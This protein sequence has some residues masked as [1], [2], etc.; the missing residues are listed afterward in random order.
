MLALFLSLFISYSDVQTV[1]NS[2]TLKV[3]KLG[4]RANFIHFHI[5]K[6]NNISLQGGS[7]LHV[8]LPCSQLVVEYQVD[9]LATWSFKHF[10]LS[11]P[12]LSVTWISKVNYSPLR[13]GQI[14]WWPKESYIVKQRHYF[15]NKGPSSQSYGFSSG[16]VWMWDLDCEETWVLKNWC[17]ELWCWRRLLRVPWTAGRSNQSVLK[18]ISPGCSLEA[19]MLK[20]KLQYFGHLIWRADSLE[21]TLL[22]GGIGVRRRRGRQDEKAGWLH[23][24]DGHEFEYPP[25]V[26]DGQGGLAC[27]DSCGRKES[28]TTER[29]NWTE[30]KE[31]Y[32]S[33]ATFGHYFIFTIVSRLTVTYHMGLYNSSSLF[34]LKLAQQHSLNI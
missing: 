27:C 24:L 12:E 8:A 34:S 25:G 21:K 11:Q 13:S 3:P 26:G 10:S 6:F 23:R 22:L 9:D 7:Q 4:W 28:D 29:L 18:E 20:L 2:P 17:F 1:L 32:W 16:H 31:P 14:L 30:P 15:A 19:L 5:L 33:A